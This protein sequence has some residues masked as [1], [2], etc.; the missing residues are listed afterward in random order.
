MS[1]NPNVKR[2]SAC[3]LA[4]FV[5]SGRILSAV[6]PA[7]PFSKDAVVPV[8]L[9]IDAAGIEALK[10]KPR[11]YVRARIRSGTNTFAETEVRPKGNF[12]FQAIARC[13]M[14]RTLPAGSGLLRKAA[15]Y[16]RFPRCLTAHKESA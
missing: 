9:R 7:T 4:A 1:D 16:A 2:F 6:E 13:A 8:D 12:T 10:L 14:R 5:V 15:E 3:I 11:E